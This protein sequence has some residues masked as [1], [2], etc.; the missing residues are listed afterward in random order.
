MRSWA[1]IVGHEGRG[2]GPH[3][4]A[5]ASGPWGQGCSWWGPG[6]L[7]LVSCQTLSGKQSQAQGPGALLRALGQQGVGCGQGRREDIWT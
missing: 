2:S 1:L 6:C 3:P 4:Q 7:A 5:E